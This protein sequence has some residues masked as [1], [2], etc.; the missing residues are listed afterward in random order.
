[1]LRSPDH[2]HAL[3]HPLLR[4]IALNRLEGLAAEDMLDG[5]TPSSVIVIEK[6]DSAAA[7]GQELGFDVLTGRYGGPPYTQ[8]GYSPSFEVI[9]EHADVFELVFVFSDYGDGAIVLIP[10]H[11]GMDLELLAL[12]SMHAVPAREAFP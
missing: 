9:E 3:E 7:L 4:A 6:G 12:C 10:K 11:E 8:A 2:A 5:D 1:V